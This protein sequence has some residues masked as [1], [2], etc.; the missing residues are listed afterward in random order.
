[1]HCLHGDLLS[2]SNVMSNVSN[3]AVYA[4]YLRGLNI[5]FSTQFQHC[6]PCEEND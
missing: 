4:Y 5:G 2:L 1:M 6:I 3:S